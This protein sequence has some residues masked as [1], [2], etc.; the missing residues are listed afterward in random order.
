M[1]RG[2]EGFLKLVV[3]SRHATEL[4]EFIEKAFDAVALTVE[5]PVVVEFFT[6]GA[7]RRNDWLDAI[8]GETLTD[9]VG[10]VAF[11]EGG[12][13]QDVVA[14]KALIE[15]FKLSAVV[16]LAR[17]Q[18]QRHAAIFIDGRGVDFGG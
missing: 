8:Y 13:F 10:I 3:A 5:R 6:A 16:G 9:P 14:I 17:G 2:A 1:E 7:D 12:G 11:V 18:M 4:F 15:A